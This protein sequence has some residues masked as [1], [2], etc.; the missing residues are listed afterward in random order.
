MDFCYNFEVCVVKNGV[1][2]EEEE[3]L[4]RFFFILWKI[5]I[6]GCFDV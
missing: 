2:V 6:V 1:V 4:L 5:G 3:I